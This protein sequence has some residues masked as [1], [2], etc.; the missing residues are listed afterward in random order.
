MQTEPALVI[1]EIVDAVRHR[2]VTQSGRGP[3]VYRARRLDQR[4]KKGRQGR[5]ML[6]SIISEKRYV[7]VG[8]P[9]LLATLA[10]F[11]VLGAAAL[12]AEAA[13][14]HSSIAKHG[15]SDVV[16]PAVIQVRG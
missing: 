11:Y 2:R 15:H 13:N 7:F 9:L 4:R 3:S 1:Q 8:L 6:N 10:L 5:A 16:L 14:F 12:F